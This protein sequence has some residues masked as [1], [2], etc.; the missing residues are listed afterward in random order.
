MRYAFLQDFRI[1]SS[2]VDG[3]CAG[4]PE[5]LIAAVKANNVKVKIEWFRDI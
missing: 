4:I 5:S 2:K 1:K 3:S